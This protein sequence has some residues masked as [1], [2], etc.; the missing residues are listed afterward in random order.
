MQVVKTLLE[1]G[2]DPNQANDKGLTPAGTCK[3]A[4][5]L[6]L[7]SESSKVK[8]EE[9]QRKTAAVDAGGEEKL[10][11]EEGVTEEEEDEDVFETKAVVAVTPDRPVTTGVRPK[12]KPETEEGERESQPLEEGPLP[13]KV[14]VAKKQLKD[15][16]SSTDAPTQEHSTSS[17]AVADSCKDS[18]VSGGAS[19]TKLI[20]KATPFFS[21][22]SSSESE[23]ELPEVKFSKKRSSPVANQVS[24]EGKGRDEQEKME[25]DSVEQVRDTGAESPSAKEEAKVKISHKD[26]GLETSSEY[27]CSNCKSYLTYITS[28]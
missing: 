2:S 25:T 9:R 1:H 20:G 14:A 23:S 4:K 8:E 12:A 21:D 24:D 5:I 7:L 11:G 27:M 10:H 16:F 22:I 3:D 13:Q 28:T 17:T 26:Q 15:D 18:T 19:L 6:K